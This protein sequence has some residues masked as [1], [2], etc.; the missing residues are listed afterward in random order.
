M[1]GLVIVKIPRKHFGYRK[2][3]FLFT[4]G[5]W[6][7]LSDYTQL[8]L[9]ELGALSNER[10]ISALFYCAAKC[11]STRGN[12]WRYTE[13]DVKK[14]IERMS[15]KEAQKIM[16]CMI[17]SKIGGE[18]LSSLIATSEDEKKKVWPGEIRDHA[19]GY[20]RLTIDELNNLTWGNYMRV[21]LGEAKREQN[22]YRHTRLLLGAL[23]HKDPREII[24]MQGDYDYLVARSKEEVNEILR[25]WGK[26]DWIKDGKAN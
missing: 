9:N 5:T 21:C 1:D 2:Q 4:M 10:F 26:T 25:I 16:D 12:P 14:W 7:M 15:T 23:I 19:I 13:E 11:Y 18:S 6:M 3:G 17:Q 20:L 8:A 22:F 24:P